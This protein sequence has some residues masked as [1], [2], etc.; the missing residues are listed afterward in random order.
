MFNLTHTPRLPISA[1]RAGGHYHLVMRNG[2]EMRFSESRPH[3]VRVDVVADGD[4]LIEKSRVVLPIG[5]AVCGIC[6]APPGRGWT[7]AD[8]SNRSFIVFRRTPPWLK[9]HR[10]IEP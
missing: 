5:V 4:R 8:D 1:L 9:R 6:I 7:I 3:A 2:V 10:S